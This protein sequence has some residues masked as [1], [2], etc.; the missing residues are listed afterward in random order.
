RQAG[1]SLRPRP[2]ARARSLSLEHGPGPRGKAA[3]RDALGP[4][5]A[6]G[7]PEFSTVRRRHPAATSTAR[8]IANPQDPRDECSDL[9]ATNWAVRT[10]YASSSARCSYL[11]RPPAHLELPMS[12]TR[13]LYAAL[14]GLVTACGAARQ[15]P[16]PLAGTGR[17]VATL[18]G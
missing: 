8:T 17:D 18:T 2:R 4:S 7:G 3:R 15:P 13:T 11:P 14:A 1:S 10:S 12:R 9:S 6:S 16:V 5:S